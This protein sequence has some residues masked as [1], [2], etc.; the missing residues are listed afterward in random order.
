MK[1]AIAFNDVGIRGGVNPRPLLPNLNP[2]PDPEVA[3]TLRRVR[4]N[5]R[6]GGTSDGWSLG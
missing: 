6:D 3:K 1:R 2:Q 5:S 4:Q